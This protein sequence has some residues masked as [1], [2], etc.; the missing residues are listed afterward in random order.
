MYRKV[1]DTSD[2]LLGLRDYSLDHHKD[3]KVNL[4][5]TVIIGLSELL[6]RS[7][8]ANIIDPYVELFDQI[9]NI[10]PETEALI[11]TLQAH[12]AEIVGEDAG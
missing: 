3:A 2:K 8:A 4:A 5:K 11:A 9:K 7:E 10:V 12:L 6:P 1:N